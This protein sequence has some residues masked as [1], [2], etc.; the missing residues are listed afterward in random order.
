MSGDPLRS[1]AGLTTSRPGSRDLIGR[2]TA[3]AAAAAT[4]HAAATG[5]SMIGGVP[6]PSAHQL[7]RQRAGTPVP[8]KGRDKPFRR[9]TTPARELKSIGKAK[10]QVRPKRHSQAQ[11]KTPPEPRSAMK[12]SRTKSPDHGVRFHS[13]CTETY[14]SEDEAASTIRRSPKTK[15]PLH[16]PVG[17]PLRGAVRGSPSVTG[18]TPSYMY[19]LQEARQH[20]L[21]ERMHQARA[22]QQ[23][24]QQAALQA[25][26]RRHGARSVVDALLAERGHFGLV[27][28]ATAGAGSGN[29]Q[30]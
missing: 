3:A 25:R 12:T 7:V 26:R 23:Q 29:A 9:V 20:R 30:F 6:A 1:R 15:V 10:D 19:S 28:V 17:A 4:S 5:N 27:A 22:H 21:D 16:L 8:R 2:A 24:E 13:S 11:R 14:F 18:A